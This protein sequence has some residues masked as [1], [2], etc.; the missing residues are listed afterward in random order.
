MVE[1]R[2]H[3]C[4]LCINIC[5]VLRKLFKH[6]WRDLASVNAMKQTFVIVILH[7]LPYSNQIHTK[8]AAKT[9]NC[10]F[11]TLDFSK[12]NVVGCKLLN[13]KMSSQPQNHVQCFGGQK[14]RRNDQSGRSGQ[15]MQ[16]KYFQ[17]QTHVQTAC[18][19]PDLNMDFLSFDNGFKQL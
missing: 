18:E 16:G 13:I 4:F 6:H 17:V 1:Y 12:Q 14:H 19:S 3:T 5:R 9:L 8:I 10:P 2:E 15:I 11:L 7:I